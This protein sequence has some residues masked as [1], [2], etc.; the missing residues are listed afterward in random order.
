MVDEKPNMSRQCALTDQKGNEILVCNK[1]SMASS[2]K[3]MILSLCPALVRSH[4]ECCVQFWCPQDKK[5]MELLQQVQREATKLTRE[6]EHL[7][8]KDRLRKLGLF[9]LEKRILRG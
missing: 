7:P 4:L 8:S 3:E 6:L 2:S 1:R 9:S 5:N